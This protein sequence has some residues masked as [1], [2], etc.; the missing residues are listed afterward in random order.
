MIPIYIYLDITSNRI[1]T[2]LFLLGFLT[3]AIFVSMFLATPYVYFMSTYEYQMT[4][5]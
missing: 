3:Y 4:A 1:D 2:I 5:N